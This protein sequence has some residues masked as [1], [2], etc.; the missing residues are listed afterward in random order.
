MLN[1]PFVYVNLSYLLDSYL[2]GSQKNISNLFKFVNSICCVFM[3]DEIDS[4]ASKRGN[5][6]DVAEISRMTIALMQEI[7]KLSGNTVFVAATNRLDIVDEAIV[8]R[9]NIIH[10]VKSLSV[11]ERKMFVDKYFHDVGIE[12]LPEEKEHLISSYNVQ[13]KLEQAIINLISNKV[14]E[15]IAREESEGV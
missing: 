12:I 11:D 2:G 4:I 8:N 1:I 10:E 5:H 3:V 13:R 15:N 14:Y 6:S 9:M 7:D